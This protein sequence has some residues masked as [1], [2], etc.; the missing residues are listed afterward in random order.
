MTTNV[1]N[2]TDIRL[3]NTVIR[4]LDWDPAVDASSIGVSA[5]EGI[6]TLTGF[7]GS[8]A[9]KLAA[10]RAVKSLRGVRAVA[11]DIVVRLM[12]ARTDE[13]IA[14]D[15]ARALSLRQAV[16]DVVQATVHHGHVTLTGTVEWLFQKK[17]A[18][19]LVRHVQGVVAIH[20]H[21]TIRP[22]AVQ[23]DIQ[24]RITRELH[25]NA[26]VDARDVQVTIEGT[27]VILNGRVQS[28]RQREA[29]E[30]AASH[31]PGVTRVDNHI[32]ITPLAL[33]TDD[34]VDE[35]C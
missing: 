33:P 12:V 19:E 34:V 23:R 31:A 5:S 10:E 15:T 18:E 35:I 32:V 6:V 9:D 13:D 26:D 27:V 4:H 16:A 22:V 1:I 25:H 28:W 30:W 8:Y 29:A 3:R 11:N 17:L 7:V 14:H 21:I 20:N 2:G 24:R